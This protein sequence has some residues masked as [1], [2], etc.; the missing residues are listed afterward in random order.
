MIALIGN[1]NVGKST[2]FN[3]LTGL[4][5]VTAHYPGK[6]LEV[7]VGE[8][9]LDDAVVSVVDLPGTYSL[10]TASDE[11]WVARQA[12]F[13]VEPDCALVVVDA[14]N[15]A[16]TLVV[17]LQV[18]DL[19]IPT[20]LA[21]NLTDEARRS[22]LSIDAD[23]L[24]ALLGIPVVST[25][26]VDGTGVAE[27]VRTCMSHS[28]S[29]DEKRTDP[30]HRYGSGFE[31]LLAPLVERA[32]SSGTEPG[33]R[34]PRVWAL[35]LLEDQENPHAG[36][37]GHLSEVLIGHAQDASARMREAR[38]EGIST[39]LSRERHGL[40]QSI[41]SE[42]VGSA[43]KRKSIA[44]TARILA[45]SPITGIP[46]LLAV[47]SSVFLFLFFIGDLLATAFSTAWR[48]FASP[49]I[50]DIVTR[51]AGDGV[52]GRTLLW[53]FD[54][55]IEASLSIGLP[56]ILTFYVLLSVLEDSGY[57]NAVAFLADRLMHKFGL[58]GRAV[59]PLV[60]GAGCSVPAVL[61]T[62]VLASERERTIACTLISMVP[63]S[64]RTAVI[65]G[66]VGHYIGIGPAMGV[67]LVSAIVT[68]LVGVALDRM[69]PGTGVGMVMEMFPFRRPS[70]RVVW[71]KAWSQFR[72]FLV[73]AT[74]I[75]VVGSIVL[76]GLYESDLLWRL[77]APFDP[78]I[79]GLLGLPSVAGLTLLFG[80]L[81]KEFAL[82]LLV[83]LGIATMGEQAS[84]LLSFMDSTDLF[85]YA[86]V[87]TLAVPC[88]STVAV[89]GK[90]LG[91]RRAS[92]VMIITVASALMVGGL[93][94]RV[95]PLL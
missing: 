46:I 79:V 10:T 3:Q 24:S 5:V 36:S 87:N 91:W 66:A 84:D 42:V 69:L 47:L 61:T 78:I 44:S 33:A 56:Y 17:A 72:E 71:R 34:P 51:I 19:G 60:S 20:V 23:R 77:S 50:I 16:R 85:V 93:F 18:I 86:L 39:T 68:G 80:V 35:E 21:L 63:C 40:A 67:F 12:L 6:T 95:L 74:P 70:L 22:G 64:A 15:L 55:G 76:G 58:H 37:D 45:T 26:A 25:V 75:V 30:A 59:I 82:Q 88:V 27:V 57:L 41:A 9:T 89:L 32:Q 65:M 1:P 4:G 43:A 2:L 7:N 13:D 49:V 62:Q 8:T 54:A 90:V 28:V 29:I 73:I 52:V 11:A 31:S 92:L 48:A 14:T 81:R 94:A 38:G 53:G 83:T